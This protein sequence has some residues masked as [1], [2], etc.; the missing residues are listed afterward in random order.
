MRL[1]VIIPVRNGREVLPS[2]LA[3]LARSTRRADEVVVV[4]DS[5]SDDSTSIAHAHEALVLVTT[6]GP[7]GPAWARNRGVELTTGD[8]LVFVDADVIVHEDTL[9][10]MAAT[11][12]QDSTVQALFGSYDASPPAPGVASRF[13]NLLHHYV[14][15]HG[16]REASSFWAGCGAIRRE[17]FR[18]VGGFD[19]AYAQP[20]V[21]DIEL[22]LRLSRARLSIR[23][24]PEI[25]AT[26]L[27]RWTLANLWRT[28]IFARAVPWTR[29]LLRE[30]HLPNDLNLGWRSRLGA[31][32]VWTA[33]AL[34]VGG[35]ALLALEGLVLA[36]WAALGATACLA[37]ST[38]LEAN[39]HRFFFR[40]GG[41]CF[42][43][44]AWLL[45][46]V[47][48][49]YSSAVFAGLVLTHAPQRGLAGRTTKRGAF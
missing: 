8:V 26:H 5:S 7:R 41:L 36:G 39:L 47:Y 9:A 29:L 42:A 23:L 16:Q 4:D 3:A 49:L 21:E 17:A 12:E 19:E 13:K 18:A 28:D 20:S 25:Q 22:G 1:S 24:C 27:K 33:T 2:C 30:R 35:A 46:H 15:Q 32:C 37:A 40:H 43:A 44:G 11:F 34:L 10:R 38:L 31:L 48:L 45:H 14:H 6:Q